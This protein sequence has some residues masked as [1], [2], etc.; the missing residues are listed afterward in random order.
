MYC[1]KCGKQIKDN[2]S[3]CPYC[4]SGQSYQEEKRSPDFDMA[5]TV[6]NKVNWYSVIFGPFHGSISKYA[7]RMVKSFK[8][9]INP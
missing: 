5:N 6:K 7:E 1:I 4:G 8:R 3:F 9:T 2:S